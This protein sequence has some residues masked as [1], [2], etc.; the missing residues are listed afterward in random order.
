MNR[1]LDKTGWQGDPEQ[2][3]MELGFPKPP[4]YRPYIYLNCVSTVDG[5]LI[6]GEPGSSSKGVGST[7]DQRLMHIIES[8]ADCVII[9]SSTLRADP[10]IHYPP[11]VYR[12]VVTTSGDLPVDHP[13]FGNDH[14][15]IV[16]A[17]GNL[18]ADNY[19]RLQQVAHIHLL[20]E[21]QVDIPQAVQVLY[22]NYEVC[23]LLV[24]GGGNLNF[25]FFDA[26]LVDE[27]F[28]TM[29]PKIKG[30]AHLPTMVDGPGLPRERV[31]QMELISVYEEAGELFLRYRRP[32]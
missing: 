3:Y 20:G 26:G 29:A 32:S 16:F 9:G 23:Y 6:L 2:L 1:L 13:F 8:A 14:K 22:Q 27:L 25:Y 31:I 12:A 11:E 19:Y 24:E 15:A 28:V 5:K 21:T 30:G 18:S 4:P 10:H 17:P 7:T